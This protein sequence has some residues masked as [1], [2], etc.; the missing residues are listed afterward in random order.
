GFHS[1]LL[2]HP[3][4]GN[5]WKNSESF[6]ACASFEESNSLIEQRCIPAKLVNDECLHQRTFIGLQ[7]FKRAYQPS[8]DSAEMDVPHEQD[9]S[10]RHF[11]DRHI[12]DVEFVKIY[13]RRATCPL[14]NNNVVKCREFFERFAKSPNQL[15]LILV[16]LPGAHVCYRPA[17]DDN[18]RTHVAR[19]FKQNGVH[20]DGRFDATGLRLKSLSSP[21]FPTAP[22]DVGVVRHVLGFEWSDA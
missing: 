11:C 19:R 13:F 20:L 21:N 6:L 3:E 16:V 15:R 8:K 1:I 9:R 5:K 2:V 17:E 18:L 14:N 7:Q 4:A 10:P 22:R 12:R